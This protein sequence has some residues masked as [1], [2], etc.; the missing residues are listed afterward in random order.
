MKAIDLLHHFLSSAD[1]VDPETTVDRIIIGDP[2][3]ELHK[4]LVT[5]ITGWRAV[6]RAAAEGCDAIVTHEPTFYVHR[7]EL[8]NMPA[9]PVAQA[10]KAFLEKKGVVV[11]RCHD[12]WDRMPDIG[13]PWA[14]ARHLG[15]GNRPAGVGAAGYQHRYDIPPVALDTLARRV[16]ERTA[17]LGE[18]AVQV[19][20][21]GSRQVAKVGIGTGCCCR[22]SVFQEM[23]CEVS[24]VCDDG[25]TYW[26]NLQL[27]DDADHSV[28]R[29]NHGTSEEPGMV[30]LAR[31]I[32]E[33]V[34]GVSA[35]HLPHG[36]SFRLVGAVPGPIHE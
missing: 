36:S 7:D 9:D 1:W 18:P 13:I 2:Q 19:L 15:L 34:P 22:V 23:G 6:R 25:T 29:V 32:D 35:T 11:L 27:A 3:K 17:L 16:A 33:H 20:G 12:V 8:D 26:S 24:I 30:T 31:Y 21:D 28:I 4:V 5:W 10:K 14:W